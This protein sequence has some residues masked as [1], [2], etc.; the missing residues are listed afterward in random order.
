MQKTE[1]CAR[2]HVT[3]SRG[4]YP[5]V[6]ELLW[7]YCFAEDVFEGRTHVCLSPAEETW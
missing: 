3:T 1:T 5:N 6:D 2:G 4:N 7:F